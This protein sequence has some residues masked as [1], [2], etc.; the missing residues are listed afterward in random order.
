M[1]QN[2]CDSPSSLYC[3]GFMAERLLR[4]YVRGRLWCDLY[5]LPRCTYV[6]RDLKALTHDKGNLLDVWLR[7]IHELCS[8][9]VVLE[10]KQWDVCAWVITSLSFFSKLELKNLKNLCSLAIQP[11]WWFLRL[12]KVLTQSRYEKSHDEVH[13]QIV[14]GISVL[15]SPINSENALC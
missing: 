4:F 7:I 12:L 14:K 13:R 5:L 6:C 1:V 15:S 11:C 8:L 10:K 9:T 3:L 2:L